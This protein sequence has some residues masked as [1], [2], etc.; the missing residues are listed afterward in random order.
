MIR[1]CGDP[2][3]EDEG[4]KKR[5]EGGRAGHHMMMREVAVQHDMHRGEAFCAGP[6][7]NPRYKGP[8]S[9]IERLGVKSSPTA[10]YCT[11]LRTYS[12]QTGKVIR[13]AWYM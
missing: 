1:R 10:A 13:V 5:G 12:I 6:T 3:S 8:S 9:F 2:A 7:S 11:H 4:N